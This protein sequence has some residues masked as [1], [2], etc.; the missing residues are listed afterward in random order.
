MA[1]EKDGST[2]MHTGRSPEASDLGSQRVVGQAAKNGAGHNRQPRRATMACAR[3]KLH[4]NQ[5]VIKSTWY[6]DTS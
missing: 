6:S 5:D 1:R 2:K 4:R 3:G